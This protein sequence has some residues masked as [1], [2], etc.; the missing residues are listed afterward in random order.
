MNFRPNFVFLNQLQKF[1]FR[2][3]GFSIEILRSRSWRTFSKRGLIVRPD[4]SHAEMPLPE[5]VS[6]PCFRRR[7][8]GKKT[9]LLVSNRFVF[10]GKDSAVLAAPLIFPSILTVTV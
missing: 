3:E 4:S 1:I 7:V 8:G 10:A 5:Q 9:T 2:I 6:H